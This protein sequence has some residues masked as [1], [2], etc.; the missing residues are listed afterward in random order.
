[1]VSTAHRRDAGFALLLGIAAIALVST[2]VLVVGEQLLCKARDFRLEERQITLIALSDAALAETLAHLSAD[3]SFD[4]VTERPLEPGTISSRV[5][6]SSPGSATVVA[7]G[8]FG[9]WQATLEAEVALGAGRPRV[10]SWTRTTGPA[11]P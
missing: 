1:M 6:T 3:P 5:R 4:G 10:L 9:Q 2:A 7:R 8:S 11:A